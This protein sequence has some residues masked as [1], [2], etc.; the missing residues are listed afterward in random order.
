MC[1]VRLNGYLQL[2]LEVIGL[3]QGDLP[4]RHAAWIVAF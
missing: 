4:H 1:R 3:A 2:I